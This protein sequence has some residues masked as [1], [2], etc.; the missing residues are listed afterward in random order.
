M[1]LQWTGGQTGW[2][3]NLNLRNAKT[4]AV[5]AGSAN[6]GQPNTGELDGYTVPKALK[7]GVT[8]AFYIERTNKTAYAYSAPLTVGGCSAASK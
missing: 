8:Y 7:C 6:N 1:S 3:L 2:Q 4:H 5:V